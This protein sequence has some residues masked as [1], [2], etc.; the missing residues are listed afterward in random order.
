MT[1]DTVT[2]FLCKL[3][4]RGK[5][6]AAQRDIAD[7]LRS[8]IQ[9]RQASQTDIHGARF[10]ARDTNGYLRNDYQRQRQHMPLFPFLTRDAYLRADFAANQVQV[11]FNG[12]AATLAAANNAGQGAPRRELVGFSAKDLQAV[13]G[14]IAQH[15]Q[16]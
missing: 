3:A 15:L 12:R 5:L 9:S 1:V 4:E 2:P 6:D 10:K 11:G 8:G 16:Q 7:V 13:Q 14:I